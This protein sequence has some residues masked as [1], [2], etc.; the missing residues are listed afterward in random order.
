MHGVDARALLCAGLPAHT[1]ARAL[2]LGGEPMTVATACA[3]ALANPAD[4]STCQAREGCPARA[5][6]SRPVGVE[7]LCLLA[8]V[9]AGSIDHGARWQGLAA[10]EK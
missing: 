4:R 1:A 8:W 7:L 2:G 6:L 3:S 10:R 5:R 9:V